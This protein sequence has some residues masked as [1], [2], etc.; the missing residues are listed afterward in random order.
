MENDLP[1]TKIKTAVYHCMLLEYTVLF[2]NE[3][4]TVC[5]IAKDRIINLYYVNMAGNKDKCLI[6]VKTYAV[7]RIWTNYVPIKYHAWYKY[8]F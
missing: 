4:V 1:K 3:D 8:G 2:K 7:L 6:K 5:K